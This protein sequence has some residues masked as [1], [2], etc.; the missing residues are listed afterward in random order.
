MS[1]L[2]EKQRAHGYYP[3]KRWY[4]D[5]CRDEPGFDPLW[6]LFALFLFQGVGSTVAGFLTG[7]AIWG[8]NMLQGFGCAAALYWMLKR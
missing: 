2:D 8:P 1:A 4:D 7:F 6:V 3:N 5:E